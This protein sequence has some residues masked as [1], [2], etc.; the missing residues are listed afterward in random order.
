MQDL[1]IGNNYTSSLELLY[2]S[3]DILILIYISS[4]S[5][6][7]CVC[8]GSQYCDGS[9]QLGGFDGEGVQSSSVIAIKSHSPK[10]MWTSKLYQRE[11]DVMVGVV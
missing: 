1:F 2:C 7:C 11:R 9:L 4:F 3:S 6:D 10:S 8:E 5:E